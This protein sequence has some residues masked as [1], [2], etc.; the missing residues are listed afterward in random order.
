MSAWFL[1]IYAETSSKISQFMVLRW[2]FEREKSYFVLMIAK[3]R[4]S[5]P[6]QMWWEP[7][8]PSYS[9]LSSQ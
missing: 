5:R 4:R 6:L 8:P 9:S 1:R 2:S 7:T 3:M